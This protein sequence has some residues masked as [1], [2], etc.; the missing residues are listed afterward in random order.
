M[1]GGTRFGRPAIAGAV[2][3]LFLLALIPPDGVLSDNEENYFQLA[4]QSVSAVRAPADSAVFDSAHH[5]FLADHL[6]G[7]LVALAG[8]A[9][10]QIIARSL[11]ALAYAV[12]L[13]A[14]FRRLGLEAL[15]AVLV[16]IVF[17][18][19]GQT[20]FGGEWLFGGAEAKVP[21]YVLV[22]AGLT[23]T[24]DGKRVGAALLFAAAT[25]FHFLVGTFWFGAAMLLAILEEPHAL[26]SVLAA[27]AIFSLLVAPLL[28]WIAWSRLAAP[29]PDPSLPAPDVLY[30]LIR[31]PHHMAP[32][33]D[34]PS[35]RDHWLGGYLLAGGMLGTLVLI[36]LPE[37]ARLRRVALWLALLIGYLVAALAASFVDRRAG[38]LGK[39][40]LFRPTAL[41]LLLWLALAQA[42]LA[43]LVRGQWPVVRLVALALAV[44]A[45][46][47][48]AAT[49]VVGEIDGQ[50]AHAPEK[51]ALA[52]YLRASASADALVL[53]DPDRD[54]AFLD[55]E[56]R[57]GHPMLVSWKFDPTTD[58]EIQEWY[59]RMEFRKAVFAEGCARR[60]AYRVDFLLTTTTHAE[61]LAGCGPVVFR[62]G[63]AVLLRWAAH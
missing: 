16:V 7:S 23:L 52:D 8:F 61:A 10:A 31:A 51:Q 49:R 63:N 30:S 26:R 32:F 55:F 1:A 50:A 14:L 53:I 9:G 34:W 57:T 60:N 43:G 48:G 6:L 42:A 27:S 54:F 20:L 18:L 33:L 38:V 62:T 15:D 46:L 36:R 28:G 29:A 21:A 45:F 22:L 13:A 17:A 56:R 19:M 37:D 11:A 5:R 59:R 58:P 12:T 35:F 2:L 3:F 25:Y 44:P 47:L 41:V 40:Y 39:F 24:L 4:L